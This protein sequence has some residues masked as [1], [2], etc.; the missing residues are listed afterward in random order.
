M[1]ERALHEP[2]W[3]CPAQTLQAW[4]EAEAA[5]A[6]H[7]RKTGSPSAPSSSR[8]TRKKKKLRD[9]VRWWMVPFLRAET[10]ETLRHLGG[11]RLFLG[12]RGVW[13]GLLTWA[14]AMDKPEIQYSER[15]EGLGV[16]QTTR[17]RD[18]RATLG[19]ARHGALHSQM[20]ACTRNMQKI[21]AQTALP[22]WTV[23][24]LLQFGA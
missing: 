21:I 1:E 18:V 7:W 17:G 4:P 6:R 16:A 8:P 13:A 9:V 19:D 22:L 24:P 3:P 15:Y 2:E 14:N 12:C 5:A 23:A 10:P 11:V 20:H